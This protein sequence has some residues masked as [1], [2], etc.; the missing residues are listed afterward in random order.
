VLIGQASRARWLAQ[1]QLQRVTV[2]AEVPQQWSRLG[3]TV[4][5]GALV[6][7][8]AL[9]VTGLF[10]L[11]HTGIVQL[12]NALHLPI[13]NGH[14][15]LSIYSPNYAPVST[16]TPY[17]PS[18]QGGS[19]S[20][21]GWSFG[22]S[23]DLPHVLPLF[24]VVGAAALLIWS[25]VLARRREWRGVSRWL[26][27]AAIALELGNYLRWLWQAISG[28]TISVLTRALLPSRKDRIAAKAP[29]DR[30]AWDALTHRQ[31]VIALYLC[32]L[33]LAAR[34]GYPRRAGQTPREHAAEVAQG[35]R[36]WRQTSAQMADLFMAARY[37][38]QQIDQEHVSRMRLLW[39]SLRRGLRR[40]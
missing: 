24:V 30:R 35:L 1:W 10:S 7:I 12:C 39:T 15:T 25:L 20:G 13:P 17:A 16:P 6:G 28:R 32:A 3:F 36:I 21:W 33:E 37:S 23:F 27:L 14:D 29:R 4:A 19:G 40:Q 38:G 8:G 11:A 34:R 26:V 2:G 18:T 22:T 31:T 5:L 9:L